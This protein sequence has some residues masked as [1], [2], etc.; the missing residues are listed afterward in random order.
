VIVLG[1]T[2]SIGM[3]K[4]NAATVLRRLGVPVH[5]ADGAVHRL[6]GPSGAAVAPIAKV[7]PGVIV[8]G[9]GGARVD[10][11]A[12]GAIVFGRPELLRRL[13][14]IVHPLVR[15]SEQQFILACRRHRL[16]AVRDGW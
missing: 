2:G 16:A 13:E 10:R 4:S 11:R 3:G 7:F 1:V 6:L 5:D 9:E 8:D 12:L 15:Q 14:A